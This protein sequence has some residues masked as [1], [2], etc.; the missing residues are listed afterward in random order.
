MFCK[1]CGTKNV[2]DAEYCVKCG[3]SLK[4]K[5]KIPENS[6]SD[7]IE[8]QNK[9]IIKRI[10]GNKI[11]L[12]AIV[13]VIIVIVGIGGS[14]AYGNYKMS[15]MDKY[16]KQSDMYADQADAEWNQTFNLL[17]QNDGAAALTECQQAAW[18]TNQSIQLLENA[19]NYADGP[20]KD[21]LNNAYTKREAWLSAENA[22]IT[23]IQ[24]LQ[25][26]NVAGADQALQIRDTKL[27]EAT[28]YQKQENSIIAQNPGMQDHIDKNW[29]ST[30]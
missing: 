3:Q 21:L 20:Y 23:A 2:E 28:D 22:Q 26:L 5:A 19:S 10:I 12:I 25:F 29:N 7:T 15:Q 16:M 24:N 14:Y 8:K 30:N 9:N 1:N 11:V 4:K 18:D 27:A 6:Q 13:A 17:N